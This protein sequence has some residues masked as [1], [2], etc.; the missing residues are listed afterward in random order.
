MFKKVVIDDAD[1]ISVSQLTDKHII[2]AKREKSN[3]GGLI[4]KEKD[5]YILRNKDGSGSTG[6]H[7]TIQDCI[8]ED[9]KYGYEFYIL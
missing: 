7:K 8:H 3:E 5:E 2:V 6:H 9:A 4:M 1:T